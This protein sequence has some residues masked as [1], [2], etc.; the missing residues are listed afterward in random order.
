MTF[1]DFWKWKVPIY[2]KDNAEVIDILNEKLLSASGKDSNELYHAAAF[3]TSGADLKC[4]V[5]AIGQDF[6]WQKVSTSISRKSL[7]CNSGR[8]FTNSRNSHM[9]ANLSEDRQHSV[10]SQDTHLHDWMGNQ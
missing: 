8:S 9:Q 7:L 6:I 1:V 10:P 5:S 3:N 2:V 4:T